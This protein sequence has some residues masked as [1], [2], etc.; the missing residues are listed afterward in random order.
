VDFAR[1]EN[2]SFVELSSRANLQ[3]IMSRFHAWLKRKA[4]DR[5][6]LIDIKH[7][8]WFTLPDPWRHISEEPSLFRFLKEQNAIFVFITRENL[9][10]QVMSLLIAAKLGIW[11]NLDSGKV[12][13][14]TFGLPIKAACNEAIKIRRG[15]AF[16]LQLLESYP[17]KIVTGYETLFSDGKLS[18]R[19][20]AEL[21]A[22][23]DFKIGAAT[24]GDI[25]V[26]TADKRE[27]VTNY[28]EVVQAVRQVDDR[29]RRKR[30]ARNK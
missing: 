10:D 26:S 24:A 29:F 28:D 25:E 14:K 13:G 12:A 27:I 21:C 4:G 16:V 17:R 3:Q 1:E 8:S 9:A 22:L 30:N 15:E 23:G 20:K 18:D 11:H 2:L 7:N 5:H 6:V 19:F